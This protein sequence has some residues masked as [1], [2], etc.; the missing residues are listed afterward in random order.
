M[1]VGMNYWIGDAWKKNARGLFEGGINDA[2]LEKLVLSLG[3]GL[4]ILGDKR[5]AEAALTDG[6]IYQL[7]GMLKDEALTHAEQVANGASSVRME[8]VSGSG[9][10]LTTHVTVPQPKSQTPNDVAASLIVAY[11]AAFQ[12][13][14]DIQYASQLF[15]PADTPWR[16]P[17]S[18]TDLHP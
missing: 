12:G 11:Q 7:L 16:V 9:T 3:A 8:V 1:S 13:A 4:K 2:T 6:G 17:T 10:V 5:F 15:V 18:F 14:E